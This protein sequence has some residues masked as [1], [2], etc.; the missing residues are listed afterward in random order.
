LNHGVRVNYDNR[1]NLLLK[2]NF[3]PNTHIK[4]DNQGLLSWT[5]EANEKLRNALK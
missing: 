1:N 5:D 4:K 2:E 3:D